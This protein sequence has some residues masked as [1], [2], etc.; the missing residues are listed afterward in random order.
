MHGSTAYMTSKR[1]SLH[2]S[3]FPPPRSSSCTVPAGRSTNR[4]YPCCCQKAAP[5]ASPQIHSLLQSLRLEEQ[6]E[7]QEQ[8]VA[9]A[10]AMRLLYRPSLICPRYLSL[11]AH[12]STLPLRIS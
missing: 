7:E 6:P 12:S 2:W 8:A 9:T 1:S 5:L 4:F 11:T 3:R 10:T